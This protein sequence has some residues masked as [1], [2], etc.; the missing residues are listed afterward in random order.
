ML[1][2]A[3]GRNLNERFYYT[4]RDTNVENEMLNCR[5]RKWY[6]SNH[7]SFGS[8]GYIPKHTNASVGFDGRLDDGWLESQRLRKLL[9][10][11]YNHGALG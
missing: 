7:V 1:A 4:T 3:T 9:A 6:R 11:L 2:S 10:S 8:R 5:I